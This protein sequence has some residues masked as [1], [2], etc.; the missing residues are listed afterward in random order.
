M[1]WRRPSE[2]VAEL[3]REGAQRV[4]DA[5]D[6]AL[7]ER[8]DEA[9][10]AEHD[11]AVAEDPVL[12]AA[13][14][15]VNR[16]TIRHWARATVEDPGAPVPPYV[17][18]EALALAFDLVR[19]GLDVRALEPYR[20]G[21]N[22]A[23]QGWME[24]AFTLTGD[25]AELQELLRVSA[26]SIFAFVDA[27][28][29]ATYE[30]FVRE[31][32]Q[33]TRGTNAERLETVTLVLEEA[34]VDLDRAARRLGHDFAR[35]QLAAI[36]W[37]DE[38]P[39]DPRA[40]ERAAEALA[41]AA[42][43]RRALAV[44]ASSAVSWVW[45]SGPRDVD[46]ADLARALADVPGVR[47]ALGARRDGVAGFRRSHFDAFATQRLLARLG[48][49]LPVA[50]YEAVRV[51]ALVTSDEAR[52]RAFVEEVLGDL[53]DGPATLRDTLRTYLREQSNATRA[54]V[55]LFT[56]RNTVLARLARAEALL[57]RPLAESAF[58]VGVA[59]EVVHWS[60]DGPG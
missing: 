8:V 10:L 57:P 48:S 4:L 33:L 14:R 12:R 32:D 41:A 28:M 23:W 60:A 27:T 42:G 55:V 40:H 17:G 16:A 38:P 18:R 35:P 21:Q 25:G 50:R 5:T 52:A 44:V 49:P 34:P 54:A 22:A 15:R 45:V 29:E 39:A 20:A 53:A 24:I 46:P 36:V 6:E 7:F 30:Q 13:F 51:V 3:L 1:A 19:R 26:R 59:L 2:R 43:A 31:R 58:E 11:A 56:H 37:S 47:V 9:S